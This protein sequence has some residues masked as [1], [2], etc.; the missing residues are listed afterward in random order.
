MALYSKVTFWDHRY[1]ANELRPFQV[2]PPLSSN[3]LVNVY[4]PV[5]SLQS[6]VRMVPG[7]WIASSPA[8]PDQL[9]VAGNSG[10]KPI[11]EPIE[12]RQQ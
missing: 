1:R 7:V 3:P 11:H 12:R 4:S 8:E 9:C 5:F 6:P 2:P 10:L